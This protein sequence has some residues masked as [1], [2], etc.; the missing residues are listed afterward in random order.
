MRIGDI[1]FSG[2]SDPWLAYARAN[3]VVFLRNAGVTVTQ[4]IEPALSLDKDLSTEVA[5]DVK[6]EP[7][8]EIRRFGLGT[9]TIRMGRTAPLDVEVEEPQDTPRWY[10]IFSD[11]EVSVEKGRLVYKASAVKNQYLTLVA[12]AANR[13]AARRMLHLNVR[14]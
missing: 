13:I 14:K 8:R 10:K 12:L 2:G 3:L 5:A 7:A 4:V 6:A 11:G 1:A 9:K